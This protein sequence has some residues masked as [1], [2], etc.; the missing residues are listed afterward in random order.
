M[1]SNGAHLHD[2]ELVIL[3]GNEGAAPRL[4]DWE[5]PVLLRR[6]LALLLLNFKSEKVGL[7]GLEEGFLYV[8]GGASG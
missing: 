5:R 3:V 6:H 8:F 4:D 2:V 1:S 7:I